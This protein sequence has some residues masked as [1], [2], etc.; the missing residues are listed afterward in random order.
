VLT[1]KSIE[2]ASVWLLFCHTSKNT[3]Y[4]FILNI[5]KTVSSHTSHNDEWVKILQKAHD[6][7]WSK[8]C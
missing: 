4:N 8:P 5:A 7:L 6:S 1:E 3:V 2:N